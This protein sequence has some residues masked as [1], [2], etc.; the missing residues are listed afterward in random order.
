M[1]AGLREIGSSVLVL[2]LVF[3]LAVGGI[4]AVWFPLDSMISNGETDGEVI[5]G[6]VLL[7]IL[8]AGTL[9][10]AV[11][12]AIAFPGRDRQPHRIAVGVVALIAAAGVGTAFVVITYP[13]GLPDDVYRLDKACAGATYGNAAPYAGPAPH[14]VTVQ[15]PTQSGQ[16]STETLELPDGSTGGRRIPRI[17]RPCN[18]SPAATWRVSSGPPN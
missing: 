11:M 18:W 6:S 7:M 8:G 4:A 1:T 2:L 5:F 15:M 17:R 3:A 16:L 12:I 14:P 13:G 10:F 9:V